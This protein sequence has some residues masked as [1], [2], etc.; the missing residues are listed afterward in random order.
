MELDHEHYQII[1]SL[2]G[3]EQPDAIAARLGISKVK[4]LRTKSRYDKA[5]LD[6]TLDQLVDVDKLV[7]INAGELT[8]EQMPSLGEAVSAVVAETSDG[9]DRLRK[10]DD[11]LIATA[12]YANSRIRSALATVEFTNDIESLVGS[13]CRLRE[14]FFNKN[15]TQVNIQNNLSN[16]GQAAYGE[17]LSDKPNQKT[18]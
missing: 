17:W 6:G 10:L 15:V 5:I 2:E 12:M 1:A 9:L 3:G 14:S 16:S 7:L 4:V 8:K 13:L 18:V 11:S